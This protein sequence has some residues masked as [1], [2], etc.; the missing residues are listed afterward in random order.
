[1]KCLFQNQNCNFQDSILKKNE[2]DP[3]GNYIQY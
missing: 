3:E 1:M 2:N